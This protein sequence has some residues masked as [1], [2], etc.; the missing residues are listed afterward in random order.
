VSKD[1]YAAIMTDSTTDIS[2]AGTPDQWRDAQDMVGKLSRRE[3]QVLDLMALGFTSREICEELGISPR[4]VEIHRGKARLKLGA[5]TSGEA[6]RLV[7]YAA[8]AQSV[9]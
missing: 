4:T 6:I 1:R 8:L 3:K 9:G 2:L 7:I 5:R